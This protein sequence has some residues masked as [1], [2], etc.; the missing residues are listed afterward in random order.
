MNLRGPE[1]KMPEVKVPPFLADLY[2]DLRDRRLLPLIGLVV[3]AIV[4]VPFLLGDSPEQPPP[5]VALGGANPSGSAAN[6]FK[7]TVVEATPGLRDYHRR[8]KS[9]TA[10][11]PF[12]QRFVAPAGGSGANDT[13]SSG[14]PNAAP[15]G[16]SVEDE[17]SVPVEVGPAPGSGS[18][19][20]GSPQPDD[21]GLRFFAFRPDVRFGVAG[22]EKL[23]TYDALEVGTRLPQKNPVVV[24]LGV[25]DDGK[26]ASFAVSPEVAVIRGK[27]Q[28]IG[29]TNSCTLLTIGA[30]HAVDLITGV[31]GR[32]YRLNVTQ[33]QFIEV[34]RPKPATS[35]SARRQPYGDFSQSFSK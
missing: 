25:S 13:A 26:R 2:Y 1:L 4:A 27:G 5:P 3:V 8:L 7:L 35:S 17:G 6:G 28:C 30:G 24:F 19:G 11:D 10:T 9:R 12:N 18:G 33:I 32:S 31:P 15:S 20:S 16:A 34:E 22:S 23:K 14:G 21:S 29:G